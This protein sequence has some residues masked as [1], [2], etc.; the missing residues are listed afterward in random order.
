MKLYAASSSKPRRKG[1]SKN[2]VSGIPFVMPRQWRYCLE[3]AAL[4]LIIVAICWSCK[5]LFH[6]YFRTNEQFQLH[7][8]AENLKITTGKMVKE[9]L[10]HDQ[11]G[12]KDGT[13]LFSVSI[14]TIRKKLLDVPSIKDVKIV[15]EMPG[16]LDITIIERTPVARTKELGGWVADSDGVVFMYNL[17]DVGNLPLI[18][19]SDESAQVEPGDRLSQMD[20]EAVRLVCSTMRPDSKLRLMEIDARNNGFLQLHFSDFRNAMIAWRGMGNPTTASQSSMQSQLDRLEQ[21]METDIG[22]AYRSF[23][24]RTSGRVYGKP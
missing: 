13:N 14:S 20:L 22:R 7:N 10:V 17:P 5:Q 11:F 12:L 9:D 16:R 15:R 21:A 2:R 8:M 24:A 3:T 19:L 23:D 1:D 4:V 6:L 18:R